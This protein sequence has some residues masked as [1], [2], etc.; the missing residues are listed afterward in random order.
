[1]SRQSTVWL[2]E[3]PEGGRAVCK[4]L[5]SDPKVYEKLKAA[6]CEYIPK[7][8]EI[9]LS[10]GNDMGQQSLQIYEEYIEGETLQEMSL[11]YKTAVN[12]A[13]QLCRAVDG[14]HSLGIIHRDIKPSN[15]MLDKNGCLKIV[16][17]SSA[18]LFKE[19]MDKDT[20]CLGTEGFA[21]PEQYGFAQTDF[22][23]DVFAV[24]QTLR[25]VFENMERFP[26]GYIISRATSFDPDKRFKSC[27]QI[28][29]LLK[30]AQPWKICTALGAAA[31]ICVTAGVM[32]HNSDAE[33]QT[34]SGY[35]TVIASESTSV[36]L[37]TETSQ[38]Y[39]SLVT[40]A[41]ILSSEA[42]STETYNI[43]PDYDYG[44]EELRLSLEAEYAPSDE[45][46]AGPGMNG[47]FPFN[48]DIYTD[49]IVITGYDGDNTGELIIPDEIEGLPVTEIEMLGVPENTTRLVIPDSVKIIQ[50]GAFLG[51]K[52]L[53]TVELGADVEY[54]GEKAFINCEY[55]RT[56]NMGEKVRYI[57]DYCFAGDARLEKIIMP[58]TVEY[59]GEGAFMLCNLRYFNIPA[60]VTVIKP[61]TFNGKP[62][63]EDDGPYMTYLYPDIEEDYS[64]KE[65][66]IPS[67][68][69]KIEHDAFSG[70]RS[71]EKVT[72]SEGVEVISA[73]AFHNCPMQDHVWVGETKAKRECLFTLYLPQSTVITDDMEDMDYEVIRY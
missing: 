72:V 10:S 17:L 62:Y 64:T 47:D 30:F 55:L 5:C 33:I 50:R 28:E 7:I 57:G 4:E 68:V 43:D 41:E 3:R 51:C 29:F 9:D 16:D 63:S 53:E 20:V 1:K 42:V 11:S 19:E 13:V 40:N 26:V 66:T 48:Y 23:T 59:L 14:L 52:A 37:S 31:L 73:C 38:T 45:G 6:E 44:I 34:V 54:I 2:C 8:Y 71:L 56:V 65:K 32:L 24:G 15:I 49:H 69:K 36:S 25:L 22:R 18:R 61:Y 70:I 60:G 58:D 35:E 39:T 21:A 12:A 27:R 46:Y 67:T